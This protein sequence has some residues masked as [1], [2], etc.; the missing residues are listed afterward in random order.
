V[1][2]DDELFASIDDDGEKALVPNGQSRIATS[3]SGR[4]H[5]RNV[6][7][8]GQLSILPGR[9]SVT[10]SRRNTDMLIKYYIVQLMIL[11]G[12]VHFWIFLANKAYARARG[13][14]PFFATTATNWPKFSRSGCRAKNNS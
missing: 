2:D 14:T 13:D 1:V 11:L 10:S 9:Y 8:I 3:V 7:E 5:R 12:G 6:R 4:L